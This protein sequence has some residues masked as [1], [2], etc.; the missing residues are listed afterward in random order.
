MV[1][2]RHCPILPQ[3]SLRPAQRLRLILTEPVIALARP[4]LTP[5]WRPR[6]ER[7]RA[8][9]RP[10]WMKEWTPH[11]DSGVS[12]TGS[13]ARTP[14]APIEPSGRFR[15]GFQPEDDRDSNGRNW[16]AD[17]PFTLR[18][19]NAEDCPQ[20]GHCRSATRTAQ[21]GWKPDAAFRHKPT[22][23]VAEDIELLSQ[24]G[25]PRSG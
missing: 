20:S 21:L 2:V 4:H 14:P 19:T 5:N 17:L 6:R 16:G 23:D 11:L 10:D 15:I 9:E 13:W 1:M 7:V 22:G 25:F 12:A 8:S 24:A 18:S 3:G